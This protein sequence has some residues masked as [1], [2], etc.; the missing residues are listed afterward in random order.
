MAKKNNQAFSAVL[1]PD[2]TPRDIV[3]I[4]AKW[5]HCRSTSK[6]MKGGGIAKFDS[7]K[8]FYSVNRQRRA[9]FD[10]PVQVG[11]SFDENSPATCYRGQ[12]KATFGMYLRTNKS[13]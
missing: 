12:I 2:L 9:N 3:V 7:R 5:I 8:V 11:S 1:L 4:P 6:I 10:L 13:K